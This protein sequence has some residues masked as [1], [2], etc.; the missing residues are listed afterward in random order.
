MK[1]RVAASVV[2]LMS[3]C[4]AAGPA[5]SVAGIAAAQ[6]GDVPGPGKKIIL[7]PA[8]GE[9]APNASARQET[10]QPGDLARLISRYF[11][12]N[13]GRRFYIQVDKPLYKP[14]ETIWFKTWDV[15]ARG[16]SGADT[17]QATV[18]LVSPKGATV[19]KKRLRTS[20]GSAT[21]DFELPAEVQGGEY[22][23]RA[24][25]GDGQKAERTI[26]VAAYEAPRL[27]KKLEFVNKAYGAGDQVSATVD[28]KRPTG[29]ALA[30]KVLTAVITVDGIEL[31][32]V[33][34]TS[35][36]EG[37]AL[38]KFDLPK[39]IETGE[40]LLT[41]LV[42]DGGVTESISKAI[43]IV[44]KKLS[45]AFYPEG[46]KM[47][48]GLP[49]RLYFEA[50]N[51]LGKPADV[52][53]RLVDDLGNA[54][55]TFG[56]YKNGLGR[57]DFTP[58]TGRTYRAEITRPSSVTEKYALPLA[59]DKGC[60]MRS[61]DDFDSQEK[62]LRVGVRCTEK[63]RVTVAATVRENVLDA[64]SVEASEDVPG[65]IYLS[66]ADGVIQNAAGVARIT[67]FDQN[68]DPLAERLVFRNR[69]ARLDVRIEPDRR[70][71]SPRGQVAL[72]ITTRDASGKGVPAELAVS[73]VDD[74]VVSLADDKSGHLLSKLL[75]EPELPGKVEEPNFYLDLTEAK[76]GQALDL[77]MGARGYRR[78]DWVAVVRPQPASV[79]TQAVGGVAGRPAPQAPPRA[80]APLPAPPVD[81]RLMKP[82]A[83][84][85]A[86][87]PRDELNREAPRE[88][89]A[90]NRIAMAE[91]AQN[92]PV[93]GGRLRAPVLDDKDF[94]R[95]AAKKVMA[96]QEEQAWAPV[97]VFP[98]PA[99]HA[100]Y[101]GPRDDYR[102]TVFWAPSVKTDRS[103]KATVKFVL[104]DAVT[105]F[106]VFSEGVSGGLAGR[107]ETVIKSSLPFSLA[108]KLPLEVSAGDHPLIPVTLSNESGR[109]LD[110]KLDAS[111]G[112]LMTASGGNGQGGA[113]A[114]GQRR[115]VFFPL[116]VTGTRGLSDVRLSAAA[117]GLN[118]EVLRRIPVVPVGF[119]QLIE[120][121]GQVNGEASYEL[122]LGQARKGS[123]QGTIRVYTSMLSTTMSGLDGMLREPNGCFEQTSST[124]YPNVMIMQYMKQHDVADTALLERSSKLLDSGYRK[125]AGY[126]SP[127][128][129]YEWFGGDPG[130]EA[131]TAYGLMQF[132]DMKD[133]YGAVDSAM[134]ARTGAWLKSRRDGNGGYLRDAKALDTFGRASPEVTDAY[135]TWALVA[136]GETGLERELAKSVK[137]AET[138]QDAYLLALAT[139][140]LLQRP[141]GSPPSKA[142]LA[143]VARLVNMQAPSGAWTNADHSITRSGGSNLTIETTSLAILALLKADGN[144]ETARKGIAW[145]Q[146]NRS[147]FG[148]WGATQATVLALKAM[149]TFDSATRVAPHA[150]AVSLAIDGV[151]VAEQAFEA[152]RREPI[153]FT[154]FDDRLAPGKHRITLKAKSGDPLP[155]SIA[156]EY[157]TVEPASSEAAVVQLQA[158]LAKAE[159]KMGETVR[160]DAVISNKTPNGQ[161][162]TLAR[163]GLPGGLT[164]Q[165][166]QLKG[167]REKGQIAFF[168]TRAREV[169]LY[170]R[171]MKP[172][173]VKKIGIDLVASVPGTYT[174]PA[175]SVYLYYND[176]NKSWAAPL[177]I[178]ITP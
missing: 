122:D 71:Y 149:N 139:G 16:L 3:L 63:Q 75:M 51:P 60:V 113:L 146:N 41:I 73:V 173:E 21:N 120:K 24:I 5:G 66:A 132:A 55:A 27:K 178:R 142:G 123:I 33:K 13:I 81:L 84:V 88:D 110:V 1:K 32:R 169:I 22:T 131:L 70:A 80:M 158:T 64:G 159:L 102:E 68:L 156:V 170:F 127:K 47:V 103:G 128:K 101:A 172:G 6:V 61:Y 135:I 45:L 86:P 154:G 141:A 65:V 46:G 136:A 129:G 133:V 25:A 97:R 166:W 78:F 155:Y 53:G 20:A 15:T 165:S 77:L 14:G 175:S 98:I 118:D 171:D 116:D 157:R 109:A 85:A 177:P 2:G 34:V 111:F 108:V 95:G 7:P 163:L 39:T 117:G 83:I 125:L 28:V 18:E 130:H 162:M 42:D 89:A 40:G 62:A 79:A 143:A 12:G 31:P 69:R 104:S 137:L 52:E 140:T 4:A 152:G 57:V 91:V 30:G 90:R 96:F 37:G 153:L 67:V 176:T 167:L 112:A 8:R 151:V 76:S 160:L 54:I 19:L 29:E 150:G 74:T 126:E 93:D 164:F 44:Q 161:P 138:T 100:D 145:L 9:F 26:F 121:S 58:A 105:T 99:F 114:A 87:V 23:L 56:T 82:Q 148:Q 43:P 124:N 107:D 35:N 17:D 144:V 48:A 134:L 72:A 119:P 36:S 50:K 94:A 92:T 147:G 49:T 115:S 10:P 38:V 106:R 11:E 168:E 174:G 59:D